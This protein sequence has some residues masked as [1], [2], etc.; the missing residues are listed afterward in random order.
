M[1][2]HPKRKTISLPRA[3]API[4]QPTKPPLPSRPAP[5]PDVTANPTARTK[6]DLARAKAVQWLA[7]TYPA[8]FG[9]DL[10]PLPLGAGRLVWPHAKA[11]GIRRRALNSALQWRTT[12]VAYLEILARD[13]AMRCDLEGNAVGP[14]SAEHRKRASEMAADRLRIRQAYV[15]S[16]G[17]RS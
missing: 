4:A 10:K 6:R 15:R 8:I 7:Q 12:L 16:P 3:A 9:L 11:A 17:L 5:Q 13:G 14:V 2:P 1:G